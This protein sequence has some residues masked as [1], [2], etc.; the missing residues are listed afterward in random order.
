MIKPKKLKFLTHSITL[1]SICIN[2]I[3]V[4]FL[5]DQKNNKNLNLEIFSESL[6]TLNHI[7]SFASSA[8]IRS[9]LL[10][11]FFVIKVVSSAKRMR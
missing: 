6:F 3:G 5:A 10:I 2:G 1:L 4:C 9:V 8:L 7:K 11:L